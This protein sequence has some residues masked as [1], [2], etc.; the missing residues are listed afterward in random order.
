MNCSV[1]IEA[2]AW[3]DG[4]NKHLARLLGLADADHALIKVARIWGW[5]TK[6]TAECGSPVYHAPEWVIE[7]ELGPQGVEALLKSGLG[8]Q[9][10]DGIYMSG[11]RKPGRIDWLLKN[12]LKGQ[13]GGRPPEPEPEPEPEVLEGTEPDKKEPE[14]LVSET[15][16]EPQ[17]NPLLSSL[18]SQ[19]TSSPSQRRAKRPRRP[20]SPEQPIPEG[21]APNET[22]AR[23]AREERVDLA[24]QAD[25]FRDHA[26]AT[27]RLTADWDAAF[28]T[29]LRK[30]NDFARAGPSRGHA[31][32]PEPV[33][34][35]PKL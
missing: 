23:L 34:R 32:P 30:A 22:H 15:P 13:K 6:Q 31:P 21:W 5:Q 7:N 14:V 3:G 8:K 19:E 17:P 2:C 18:F 10:P 29:W 11:T 35:L 20:A 25:L 1:R 9:E 27:A 12:K 33:R 16:T 28:R 24:R 4:R 26:A